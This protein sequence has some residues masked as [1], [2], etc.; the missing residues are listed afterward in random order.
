MLP[1]DQPT[2]KWTTKQPGPVSKWSTNQPDKITAH[3]PFIPK[4]EYLCFYYWNWINIDYYKTYGSPWGNLSINGQFHTFLCEATDL[5]VQTKQSKFQYLKCRKICIF[6]I[7][8][9]S[10]FWNKRKI[11]VYEIKKNSCLWN[12]EKF[13]FLK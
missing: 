6:E 4:Y 11:P 5:L 3:R 10:H 7:K 2:S 1:S 8:K 9:N 13:L 12:K